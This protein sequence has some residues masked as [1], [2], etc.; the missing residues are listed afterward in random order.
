MPSLFSPPHLHDNH[1][2][3]GLRI[4]L[5]GGSFNPPHDGHKWIAETALKALHLD[6]VWWLVSPGNPLK[7]HTELAAFDVRMDLCRR[8]TAHHPRM[9]VS[10]LEARLGITRTIDSLTAIL[11]LYPG[12]QFVWVGGMDSALDFH[13]WNDWRAILAMVP[14]AF[15]ARPPASKL[16]QNC[17]LR[18]LR[19]Q[20]NIFIHHAHAAP[21]Y[22]H[23]TYWVLENNMR[24]ISSTA[25]RQALH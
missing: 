1:R 22:P 2:W 23:R 8:L 5:F 21:L 25:L 13:R 10:D 17:P 9:I 6:C 24:D 20:E 4:G 12:A 16:V 3:H 19:G 15:I 7:S 11:P 18:M 14:A